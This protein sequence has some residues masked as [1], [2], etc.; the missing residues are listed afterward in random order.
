MTL[1]EPVGSE[2]FVH[3]RAG[4]ATIVARVDAAARPAP[5]ERVRVGVRREDVHLF[6]EASGRRV[7]WT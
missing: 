5:R 7:E 3:L 2:A 6:D 4:D 1:V